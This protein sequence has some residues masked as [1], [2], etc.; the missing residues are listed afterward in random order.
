MDRPIRLL[1]LDVDGTLVRTRSGNPE[2]TAVFPRS[3]EE[4]WTWIEGVLE[5][6][7]QMRAENPGL[8]IALAT[9]QGG[10][11]HGYHDRKRLEFEI[12]RVAQA[13]G[14]DV[15]V[16]IAWGMADATNPE[17]RFDDPLRKPAP[18]AILAAMRH[19]GVNA[20]DTLMVG[21]RDN[22]REA[23]VR[24]GCRFAWAGDFFR[25]VAPPRREIV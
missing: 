9:N 8:C 22:D 11:G 23:A 17:Y 12:N 7:A 4:D 15:L 3:S 18:G 14:P 19:F 1:C 20:L 5:K 24:T 2:R 21:D 6:I 25:S 10:V 16:T 13:L